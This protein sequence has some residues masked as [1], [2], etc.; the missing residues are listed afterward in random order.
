MWFFFSYANGQVAKDSSSSADITHQQ[1]FKNEGEQEDYWAIDMFKN[2]YRPESYSGYD[3]VIL[4]NG[5]D[6]IFGAQVITIYDP[7][8]LPLFNKGVIYPVLIFAAPPASLG[9]DVKLKVKLLPPDTSKHAKAIEEQN[10][11]IKR[12]NFDSLSVGD[13]Q[14]LKVLET[15][16]K[17]RRFRFLVMIK[18][19]Q[20][21]ILY[22]MELTNENATSDTDLSTFIKA[23][24]LTF[25]RQGSVLI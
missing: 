23:A 1:D 4:N 8:F 20:N 7:L 17:H 10:Q 25:I 11:L 15:S 18:G 3:K 14:E 5:S 2:R 19:L 9:L 22:F 24:N 13:F 12:P 21:P 6:C 16:P